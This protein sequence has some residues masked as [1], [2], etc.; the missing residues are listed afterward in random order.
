MKSGLSGFRVLRIFS[1]GSGCAARLSGVGPKKKPTE[2]GFGICLR[3]GVRLTHG[4]C[5]RTSLARS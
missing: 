4:A 3:E 2:V 1:P 5:E